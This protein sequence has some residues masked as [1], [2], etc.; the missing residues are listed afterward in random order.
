MKDEI[1]HREFI[2]QNLALLTSPNFDRGAYKNAYRKFYIEKHNRINR[3]SPRDLMQLLV[4]HLRL[5][6]STDQVRGLINQL[7]FFRETGEREREKLS[8]LLNRGQMK[9]ALTPTQLETMRRIGVFEAVKERHLDQV[10]KQTEKE[11]AQISAQIDERRRELESL[12]SILD[13]QEIEEPEFNPEIE[14]KKAWW[15]RFYL[16]QDPFPRKDG[17]SEISPELYE[18]ITI[19]TDPFQRILGLLKRDKEALFNTGFLLVGDYGYGKTTFVDYLSHFLIHADILPLRITSAKGYADASGFSDAFLNKLRLELREEVQKVLNRDI[20][21]LSDHEVEDQI[22][23]MCKMLCTRK[24]GL[25]IFMDDFHKFRSHFR[26]IFEFLGTLQVLK[27]NL[28]REHAN[29][30]FIVSGVPEWLDELRSNSQ[31]LGFLDSEPIKLPDVSPELISAV[32][33][34]RIAAFCFES[35]PRKIKPEFVRNLVRD[36][37]GEQGIRGCINRIVEELSNNNLAIVDSPLEVPEST[38]VEIKKTLE[39]S[40]EVRSALNKLLYESRFR[41]YSNEQIAKCLEL[42]V[43]ISVQNGIAEI[44]R[45]F[46]ESSFYFQVL[47][48]AGLIQKQRG[49]KGRPFRWNLSQSFANI[50]RLVAKRHA[51]NPADYLLKIYAYKGYLEYATETPTGSAD[52]IAEVKHLFSEK[53]HRLALPTRQAMAKGLE[54]VERLLLRRAGGTPSESDVTTAIEAFDSLT[55]AA[56]LLDGSE[57]LFAKL[58]ITDTAVRWE[59]K[60][61]TP[62]IVHE[63]FRR[64]EDHKREHSVKSRSHAIKTATD[65]LVEIAQSIKELTEQMLVDSEPLLHRPTSHVVEEIQLFNRIKDGFFSTISEEHFEYMRHLVDYLERRLRRF[66]YFTANLVFGDRYFDQ[67]PSALRQYAHKNISARTSFATVRNSFDGLTR[68]QYRTILTTSNPLRDH[69]VMPLGVR[70]DDSAWTLFAS[71]FAEEN[72]KVAH[73][74]I[75]SFSA[76]DKLSYRTFARQAEEITAA[77][78]KMVANSITRNIYLVPLDTTK[79]EEVLGMLVTFKPV[80]AASFKHLDGKIFSEWPD[81]PPFRLPVFRRKLKAKNVERIMSAIHSKIRSAPFNLVTQ[82][83]LDSEYIQTHYRA[84]IGDFVGTLAW[85]AHQTREIQ[86]Q[87]WFGSSIAITN[88]RT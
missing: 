59:L 56:G 55:T 9:S 32:F 57:A 46:T 52:E 72:I 74:Q 44:D 30:G 75:D 63:A 82:D 7:P 86:V 28:T 6:M 73:L 5:T 20:D 4:A 50:I 23:R 22:V 78:C 16:R 51:L 61:G 38:L 60:P 39:G 40:P 71:S 47:R 49:K 25:V 42:L 13:D 43:H 79:N 27:D 67:C 68:S 3:P 24:R 45:Q 80:N 14:E 2:R 15:E 65:A 64:L 81:Q 8:T 54:R 19:K 31:L 33:N 58:G 17:L 10:K 35:T 83:L 1:F 11:V 88:P 76:Q 12:P 77:I 21:R 36:L 29:V 85:G 41:R 37:G 34:H 62:E 84:T 48:D 26:Q 69:C 53:S 87:P 70:W 66:F 18:E